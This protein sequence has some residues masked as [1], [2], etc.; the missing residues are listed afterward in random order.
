MKKVIAITLL[1]V[2]IMSCCLL[3]CTP[4]EK[5]KEPEE[6]K[7]GGCASPWKG[8]EI[9]FVSDKTEFDID[10]VTLKF[11][12]GSDFAGEDA[13]KSFRDFPTMTYFY[14]TTTNVQNL[15]Q[16]SN[17]YIK[18]NYYNIE[19][20]DRINIYKKFL[21]TD[22]D[23]FY[24]KNTLKKIQKDD[25]IIEEIE[26]SAL[27]K[28]TLTGNYPLAIPDISYQI[29]IPAE[30][31]PE[32]EG[33]ISFNME[34]YFIEDFAPESLYYWYPRGYKGPEDLQRSAGDELDAVYIDLAYERD[35]RKITLSS[36][37]NAMIMKMLEKLAIELREKDEGIGE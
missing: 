5:E 10:D 37:T 6:E 23:N 20:L 35:G 1:I 3:G 18:V 17:E 36:D 24:R 25:P 27:H 4:K 30:L 8:T 19:T 26:N 7:G 34:T 11:Y 29:T 28:R 21:Y 12:I 13:T 31:F 22:E 14:F 33:I 32:E 16:S 9:I 2:L 15:K